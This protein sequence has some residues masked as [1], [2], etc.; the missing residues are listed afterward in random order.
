M[1]E[2]TAALEQRASSPGGSD[3]AALFTI[4]YDV[5]WAVTGEDDA[6]PVAPLAGACLLIYLGAVLLDDVMDEETSALYQDW[7]LDEVTL[8]G[9]TLPVLAVRLLAAQPE[10]LSAPM[11]AAAL[12]ALLEMSA[13]QDHDRESRNE[14]VRPA[15]AEQIARQKT[16]ALVALLALLPALCGGA[17]AESLRSYQEYGRNLGTAFEVK[18]AIHDLVLGEARDLRTGVKSL[19]IALWWDSLESLERPAFEAAL[20]RARHDPTERRSLA[21]RIAATGAPAAASAVVS[22]LQALALSALAAASPVGEAARHLEQFSRPTQP[23]SGTKG[24][25]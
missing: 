9:A 24:Q 8:L 10:P 18:T 11:A 21:D 1:I 17:S 4:P 14:W 13:G 12:D 2:L 5:Y 20:R 6:A 15:S 22:M 3:S 7:P 25:K 16:G 19:P 23:N